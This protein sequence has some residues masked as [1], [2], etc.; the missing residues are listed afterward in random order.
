MRMPK[1][2]KNDYEILIP[3]IR[4]FIGYLWIVISFGCVILLVQASLE[5]K[6]IRY[7]MGARN[8]EKTK[9][10]DE[11]RQVNNQIAELE[12]FE[13]IDGLV[14]EKLPQLGPP[15]YPAI[16]IPVPGLQI[17][18]GL[19]EGN[20]VVTKEETWAS[21]AR[22]RWYNLNNKIRNWAKSLVE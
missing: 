14:K 22:A 11:L 21:K 19:P 15:R 10:M 12:R 2:V 5:E 4:G 17:Q 8:L 6:A 9:L 16:E 20:L 7:E 3:Y 18:G 13:R 1:N